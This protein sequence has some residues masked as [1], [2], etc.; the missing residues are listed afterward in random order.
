M[1]SIVMSQP[2]NVRLSPVHNDTITQ[3]IPGL[4]ERWTGSTGNVTSVKRLGPEQKR[5]SRPHIH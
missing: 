3:N 1:N 2:I 5:K 4:S